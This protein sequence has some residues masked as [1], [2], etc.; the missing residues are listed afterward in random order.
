MNAKLHAEQSMHSPSTT[1]KL[2]ELV[3]IE[4]MQCKPVTA[5]PAGE[6]WAFDKLDGYRCIT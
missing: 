6:T 3:F 5:L 4:P 1:R 2:T